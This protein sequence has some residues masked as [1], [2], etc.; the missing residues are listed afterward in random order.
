MD[1]PTDSEPIYERTTAVYK[2]IDDGHINTVQFDFVPEGNEQPRFQVRMAIGEWNQ[3]GRPD[4]I[5]VSIAAGDR[6]NDPAPA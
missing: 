1:T 3:L 2:R 6:L 4:A 5:T